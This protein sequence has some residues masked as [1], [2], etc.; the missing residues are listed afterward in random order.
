M[1]KSKIVEVLN[2]TAKAHALRG[3]PTLVDRI[4]NLMHSDDEDREKSSVRIYDAY[5]SASKG[6]QQV[7]DDIFISLCGY[8]LQSLF[9]DRAIGRSLR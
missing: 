6:A 2:A 4:E 1:P 8:Q 9:T 5:Q 7:I 3:Y